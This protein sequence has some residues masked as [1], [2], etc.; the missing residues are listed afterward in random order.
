MRSTGGVVIS[1]SSR[2]P[3]KASWSVRGIGVAFLVANGVCAAIVLWFV[4]PK[5][6]PDRSTSEVT[7]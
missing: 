3:V 4:R 1:E 6:T 5:R 2:T 7:A